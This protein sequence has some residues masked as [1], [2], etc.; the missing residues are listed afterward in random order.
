MVNPRNNV[1]QPGMFFICCGEQEEQ[2]K[3]IN[4]R[5]DNWKPG[6][7]TI[8]TIENVAIKSIENLIYSAG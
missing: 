1:L 4:L 3:S 6:E 2:K 5:L 8:I 7:A